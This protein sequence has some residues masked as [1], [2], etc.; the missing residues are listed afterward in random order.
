MA[1]FLA[2][3]TSSRYLTVLAKKGDKTVIRHIG[4]CAMQ[5]S[6][7][8]MGEIE[9]A[10]EEAGLTPD[11]CDYFAAV[12]GPGSFTGIR[13]GVATIKGF[14]YAAGK[15]LKGVTAFDLIAYNVNS[16]SPFLVVID[17]AHDHYYACGYSAG[18]VV[19]PPCYLS[20]EKVASFGT[21]VYGF[22]DLKFEN[23]TRLA[24]RDCI[25]KAVENAP[26]SRDI[27]ALY[28]RRSQAEETL[29][30]DKKVGI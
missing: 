30:A 25:L 7:I 27:H 23:Y 29:D 28:V 24:V 4:D 26:K 21:P 13:I 10:L 20:A 1:D 2:V 19:L 16:T 18:E 8:L 22:E 3:D 14:A 15:D 5:H 6:V 17:A 12:T 11:G 9:S